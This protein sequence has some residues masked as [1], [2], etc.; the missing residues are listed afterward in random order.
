LNHRTLWQILQSLA[1]R[2]IEF[3]P[4]SFQQT[5]LI[6]TAIHEASTIHQKLRREVDLFSVLFPPVAIY[7]L[8][9]I[10]LVDGPDSLHSNTAFG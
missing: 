7:G 8:K 4:P 1:T 6:S 9:I 5:S 2:Q 3:K 10:S